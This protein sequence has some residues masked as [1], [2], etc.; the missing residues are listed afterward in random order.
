M[1]QCDLVEVPL[2]MRRSAAATLP[3]MRTGRSTAKARREGKA[4]CVVSCAGHLRDILTAIF[5]DALMP[6]CGPP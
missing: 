1:D 3:V 2:V 5:N 4:G 6:L